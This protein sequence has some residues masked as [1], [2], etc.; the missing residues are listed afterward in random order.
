MRTLASDSSPVLPPSRGLSGH[1]DRLPSTL[2]ASPW[3][4]PSLD[5]DAALQPYLPHP[6][7]CL[8]PPVLSSYAVEGVSCVIPGKSLNPSGPP[9]PGGFTDTRLAGLL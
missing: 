9:L 2:G 5:M 7:L 3:T 6:S 1:M 8:Q 4:F